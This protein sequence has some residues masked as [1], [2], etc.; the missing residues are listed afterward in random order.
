VNIWTLPYEDVMM[1]SG[2]PVDAVKILEG[3]RASGMSYGATQFALKAAMETKK[4]V[5]SN[6][7]LDVEPIRITGKELLRRYREGKTK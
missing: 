2:C 7:F 6:L 1:I 3:N 5:L 4:P